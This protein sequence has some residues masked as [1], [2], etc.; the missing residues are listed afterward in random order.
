MGQTIQGPIQRHFGMSCVHRVYFL[1]KST[2]FH[3]ILMESQRINNS[4]S[5]LTVLLISHKLPAIDRSL[6]PLSLPNF[7]PIAPWSDKSVLSN[8]FLASEAE[9]SNPTSNIAFPDPVTSSRNQ[10]SKTLSLKIHQADIAAPTHKTFCLLYRVQIYLLVHISPHTGKT[11]QTTTFIWVYFPH[12]NHHIL[13]I[14]NIPKCC[15]HVEIL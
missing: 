4:H 14:K 1:R 12:I 15:N 9:K 11:V 7:S 8:V 5:C 3:D 2:E 13:T 10:P 6:A